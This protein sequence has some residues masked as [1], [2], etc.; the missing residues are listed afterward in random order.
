[1]IEEKMTM[2]GEEI[3]LLEQYEAKFGE[4]PPVFF[5]DSETSKRMLLHAIQNNKPFNENDVEQET[6]IDNN[7]IQLTEYK[8]FQR[9][10]T[11][12]YKH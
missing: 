8:R 10:D 7:L 2:D 6:K 1:M 11:D 12:L 9:P 3:E 5:M 4:T